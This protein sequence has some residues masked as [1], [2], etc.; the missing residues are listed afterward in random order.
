MITLLLGQLDLIV[1]AAIVGCYA[2]RSR[3]HAVA[4]GAVLAIALVKPH[5][6]A[7]TVLMLLLQRDW[8][9]LASFGAI[10]APLLLAPALFF[11][12]HII[13]DQARLIASYPGSSTEHSVAAAMMVNVRGAAV[14]I[15]GSSNVWLWLP[16]LLVIAATATFGA[17][18]HRPARPGN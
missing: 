9:T 10:G 4:A 18:G 3:G 6:A 7:A 17:S 12:P 13:A 5:L 1:V 11:G 2:L 8:R 14:S 15:T 16:P